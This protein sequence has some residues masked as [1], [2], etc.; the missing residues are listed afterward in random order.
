M[1]PP[2]LLGRRERCQPRDGLVYAERHEPR[3]VARDAASGMQ[4]VW[5]V[6]AASRRVGRGHRWHGSCQHTTRPGVGCTR[7]HAC[8]LARS[9]SN[10]QQGCNSLA[11][12]ARRSPLHAAQ[13]AATPARRRSTRRHAH[14]QALQLIGVGGWRHVAFRLL[15]QVR[16]QLL[17][18]S[19]GHARAWGRGARCVCYGVQNRCSEPRGSDQKGISVRC[20]SPH[21]TLHVCAHDRST[22]RRDPNGSTDV[23]IGD[24]LW[25]QQGV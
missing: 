4:G 5:C 14:L 13:H 19:R 11:H 12:R 24:A 7:T 25:G 17:H 3:A 21:H 22:L 18:G 8:M 23:A 9:C 6:R 15:Q 20:N 1:P 16:W 2:G 10:T